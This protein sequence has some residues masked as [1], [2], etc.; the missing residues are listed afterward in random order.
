[1][2]AFHFGRQRLQSIR[3]MSSRTLLSDVNKRQPYIC[4]H[5]RRKRT[6]AFKLIKVGVRNNRLGRPANRK[7]LLR[8]EQPAL[9]GQ[10]RSRDLV[11][12]QVLARLE[13]QH[14]QTAYDL[15]AID[16]ALVPVGRPVAAKDQVLGVDRTAVKVSDLTRVWQYR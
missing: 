2:A 16:L 11:L 5:S 4:K 15:G 7:L 3:G 1:M 10:L 6:A 12:R 8:I 14:I 9:V 13:R